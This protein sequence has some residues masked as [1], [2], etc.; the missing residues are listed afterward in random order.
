MNRRVRMVVVGALLAGGIWF[1]AASAGSRAADDEDKKAVKEAQDAIVKLTDTMVK[2]KGNTKAEAEAIR[3]K[4]DDLKPIMYIFKPR[5]K[6]GIGVGPKG[7]RDGIEFRFQDLGKKSS[8][9][10]QIAKQKEDLIRAAQITKAVGDVADLY[11]PK[12][13]AAKWKKYN[14]EMKKGA[15]ELIEALEKGD[16]AKIKAAANNVNSSCNQCHADFR[17]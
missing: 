16:P 12:K 8:A 11:V 1:L 9:A 15:D 5:A 4:F 14:Q 17:D 13:D 10:A 6:G 3:K 7:P 2:G